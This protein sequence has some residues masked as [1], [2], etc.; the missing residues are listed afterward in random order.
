MRQRMRAGIMRLY[1]WGMVSTFAR[2]SPARE[3]ATRPFIVMLE[4]IFYGFA[5]TLCSPLTND[6]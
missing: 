4:A 2:L 1:T 6:G 3:C 5:A